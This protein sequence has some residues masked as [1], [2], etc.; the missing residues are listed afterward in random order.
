MCVFLVKIIE[1]FRKLVAF[2]KLFIELTK[3]VSYNKVLL[4]IATAV[5]SIW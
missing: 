1:Q 3:A 2:D 5:I 4:N